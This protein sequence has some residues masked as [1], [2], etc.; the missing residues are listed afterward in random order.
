MKKWTKLELGET[1][2]IPDKFPVSENIFKEHLPTPLFFSFWMNPQLPNL[3]FD[4]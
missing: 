3:R 1:R 4:G 2:E